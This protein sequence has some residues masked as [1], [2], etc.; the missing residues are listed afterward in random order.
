MRG[1]GFHR[2]QTCC[3]LIIGGGRKGRGKECRAG[4][5]RHAISDPANGGIF[6][7]DVRGIRGCIRGRKIMVEYV[8]KLD[9]SLPV[10][11]RLLF[12]CGGVG[13]RSHRPDMPGYSLRP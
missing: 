4:H 11:R 10:G 5:A 13:G 9:S 8:I 3:A 2:R 12:L 1:I 6:F 7:M